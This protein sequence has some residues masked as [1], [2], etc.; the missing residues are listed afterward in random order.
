MA[1]LGHNRLKWSLIKIKMVFPSNSD[2][3]RVKSAPGHG[4]LPN[5][6]SGYF[7]ITHILLY[8]TYTFIS[9]T[10]FYIT[11][12]LLYHTHTYVSHIYFYITHILL[13]HT[14]TFMSHTYLCITHI[15]LYHTHTF[16]SHIL[17]HHTMCG[18]KVYF[19]PHK[20]FFWCQT[21]YWTSITVKPAWPPYIQ[22]S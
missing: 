2:N 9:H 8:H 5:T 1:P 22:P 14:Y 20:Y 18:I 6:L 13:Y 10:Y 21:L 7:Y 19:I 11:H 16:I 12:I 15:L 3:G 4:I 17:L